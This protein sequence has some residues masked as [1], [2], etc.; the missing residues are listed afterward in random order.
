[1]SHPS[2]DSL[3]GTNTLPRPRPAQFDALWDASPDVTGG[4]SSAPPPTPGTEFGT[5]EDAAG[6]LHGMAGTFI[7]AP[8]EMARSVIGTVF[9]NPTTEEM[10]N[11]LVRA[12][13]VNRMG[14]M[15]DLALATQGPIQSALGQL[16]G[17]VTAAP[18][19]AQQL[20]TQPDLSM[21]QRGELTGGLLMGA[22]I[23]RAGIRGLRGTPRAPAPEAP[24]EPPVI[25]PPIPRE[26]AT[27]VFDKLW[28][29]PKPEP[30]LRTPPEP[31]LPPGVEA[32][33]D[34]DLLVPRSALD[35]E[36]ARKVSFPMTEEQV[37]GLAE[38]KGIPVEQARRRLRAAGYNPPDAPA[39][40]PEAPPP[41]EPPPSSP[42]TPEP[43]AAPATAPAS[44]VAG[45]PDADVISEYRRAKDKLTTL[46]GNESLG[47]VTTAGQAVERDHWTRYAA[48]LEAAAKERGLDLQGFPGD[49][50]TAPAPAPGPIGAQLKKVKKAAPASELGFALPPVLGGLAGAA[51]GATLGSQDKEGTLGQ[52]LMK[53]AAGAVMGGLMGAAATRG[54]ARPGG[55]VAKGAIEEALAA[56]RP[57]S[58]AP[59]NPDEFVNVSKF[60]LD[61]SGEMRLRHEV[62]RVVR[63]EG[64]APKTKVTWEETRVLAKSIGIDDLQGQQVGRLDGPHMLAI[65]N[66]VSR[67]VDGLTVLYRKIATEAADPGVRRQVENQIAVLEH[68]NDAL[69]ARFV[70]ARTQTGRDLNNL[71]ILA[72]RNMDPVTWLTKAENLVQQGGR[73]LTPAERQHITQLV[74]GGDRGQ[75][76]KYV[77][78]LRPTSLGEQV[79]SIWKAGLLT[80]PTTHAA[81][82]LG[83]V[84]MAALETAKDAPAAMLDRLL[85]LGTGQRSKAFSP[86][87]TL[88]ASWQG[89]KMGASEAKLVLHG[90]PLEDALA[91]WDLPKGTHFNNPILDAYVNGVFRSL[92]AED[93]IFRGM[94]LHRSLAEQ[95]K[96]S[97]GQ[98]TDAIALQAVRDAEYATFKTRTPIPGS[99]A[100]EDV[101]AKAGTAAKRKLGPV[102]EAVLPFTSTPANVV[103]RVVEYSP[104]GALK[105][106]HDVLNLVRGMRAGL[107][108]SEIA[109]L[110]RT[111]AESGGRTALGLSPVLAGYLLAKHGLMLGARPSDKTTRDEWNLEGKQENAVLLGG[112][113]RSVARISPVGNLM[114]LGANL[115]T[116]RQQPGITTGQVLA[117]GAGSIGT[118]VSEQSFLS[119]LQD[120]QEALHDPIGTAGRYFTNLGASI[121]PA[122]VGRV[123]RAVDPTIRETHSFS[124]AL[125]ARVPG[126]SKRLPPKINQLGQEARRQGG[127]AEVFDPASSR[128]DQTQGSPVIAEMQRVGAAIGVLRQRPKETPDEYRARQ[129]QEGEA[130]GSF[131]QSLMDS[132]TYQQ[133]PIDQQR[134]ALEQGS[135]RLRSFFTRHQVGQ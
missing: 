79:A 15:P 117:A 39:T 95:L 135:T 70:K 81:N 3:W 51:G 64:M 7:K 57:P 80:S 101:L 100:R 45:F 20:A 132:P 59:V 129:R 78:S 130:L 93:R 102:S 17:T 18:E 103:S 48:D 85:S 112:K 94:A 36:A 12:S 41:A 44:D 35:E 10:A 50:P 116:L 128:M 90:V 13:I 52:R 55:A 123:A 49:E 6:F 86:I 9:G 65:R 108:G 38:A 126:L 82:I 120:A 30:P 16:K 37:R 67:N 74:Q 58:T 63:R 134:E 54:L 71:K 125:Q 11:P 118:T 61:P 1:M 66:L 91:K 53:G 88:H 33:P 104:L 32:V 14:R 2:F 98:M 34:G 4:V 29:E 83:N 43:A 5:P 99:S 25:E 97:G 62:E 22:E 31:N 124:E 19:A 127:L 24:T 76:V 121:V 77:A 131:V 75:L 96:V 21:E 105:T 106:A 23:G 47:P 26:T 56:R 113:W 46:A 27:S 73:G 87:R 109:I 111:A 68:Q 122:I 89:A 115:Y 110:Q 40:P 42:A 107:S 92:E 84:T 60:A 119:G 8:V 133:M 72:N 28:D 114:S 69:L